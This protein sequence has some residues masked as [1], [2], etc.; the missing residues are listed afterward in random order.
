MSAELLQS[1]FADLRQKAETLVVQYLPQ[2]E[3][4]ARS[5]E[6]ARIV[7]LVQSH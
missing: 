1:A 5:I 7:Q 4:R 6:P 3:E 2:I